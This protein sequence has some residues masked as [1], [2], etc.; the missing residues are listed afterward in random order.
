MDKVDAASLRRRDNA[1]FAQDPHRLAHR[2]LRH[3]RHLREVGYRGQSVL[4]ALL[5]ARH[6]L[7]KELQR[8]LRHR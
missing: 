6:E 4:G 8:P 1:L 5:A 3:P 7:A 2:Y